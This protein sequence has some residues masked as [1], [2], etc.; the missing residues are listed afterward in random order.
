MLNYPTENGR[1]YH[2]FREGTY[3][4]PNDEEEQDRMDI[5]HEMAVKAAHGKLHTAPLT[6][7]G[8][9]L[10]IGTGTGIWSI[11]MGDLFP[12]SEI[13]GNDFSPVQP[14]MVPRNVKFEVDDVEAPWTHQ[15]KFDY[16]HCRFMAGS[17]TDW[18]K[19]VRTIYDNLVPGGIAEFQDGDFRIYSEDGS[20]KGSW[21]ERWNQEFER[22]SELVGRSIRPGPFFLEWMTDVG[23]EDIHLEKARLPVGVWPKDKHLASNTSHFP[24]KL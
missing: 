19:L 16:I 6:N 7:P 8:R 4:F 17:I 5:H 14:N 15:Q 10:D 24:S 2:A 18:P 20:Y 1:R 22:S 11:E 12:D 21:F 13:I 23:F 9:I 3:Y